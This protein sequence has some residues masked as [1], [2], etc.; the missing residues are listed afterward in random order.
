M[1][2][3]LLESIAKLGHVGDIVTVRAGF[4]RNY[5]LPQK[6]A[7]AS[8][9]QNKAYFEMQKAAIEAENEKKLQ[10]AS[11]VNKKI[12]GVE[13]IMLRTA[14]DSG[15]L[16]G[17]VTA[18]D[19]ASEISEKHGIELSKSQVLL[20]KPMKMIGIF[21][22]KIVLHGDVSALISVNVAISEVQATNQRKALLKEQEGP[23]ED[24]GYKNTQKTGNDAPSEKTDASA[25]KS[26][27]KK[28]KGAKKE[29]SEKTTPG[30]N[31]ESNTNAIAKEATKEAADSQ[32]AVEPTKEA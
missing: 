1:E 23:K 2:I 29:K 17:S 4:A 11:A 16:Y 26:A 18:R 5:L 14:G 31:Q 24:K 8:N 9:K 19:I 32:A 20:E 28:A 10:N 22:Q 13:I 27:E 12:D 30:E 25:E 15:Q 3:I 7:L 6:R 21:E